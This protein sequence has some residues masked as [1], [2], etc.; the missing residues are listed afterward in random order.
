M[1]GTLVAARDASGEEGR[2]TAVLDRAR[3]LIRVEQPGDLH[4]NR[5][6]S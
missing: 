6:A 5:V 4:V 1:S 3:A 2:A